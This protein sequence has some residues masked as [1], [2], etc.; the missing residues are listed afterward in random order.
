M[1]NNSDLKLTGENLRRQLP[2]ASYNH[3]LITLCILLNVFRNPLAAYL[4]Q[5]T[6]SIISLYICVAQIATFKFKYEIHYRLHIHIL[7]L[8]LYALLNELFLVYYRQ[9]D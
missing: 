1:K 6:F 5:I 4:T 3:E 7:S 2:I 9:G 8:R